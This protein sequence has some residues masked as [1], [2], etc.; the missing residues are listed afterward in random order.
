MPSLRNLLIVAGAAL[1]AGWGITT[2]LQVHH[3]HQ[4]TQAE[5]VSQQQDQ[6]AQAHAQAAQAIPHHAAALAAA[7]AR[8]DVAE[9][10]AKAAEAQSGR[11]LKER[12][13][14]LAR[15]AAQAPAPPDLRDQVIAKDK[16]VI[17][18]QVAQ[19]DGLHG[20]VVALEGQVGQL[21]LAFSDEQARSA[22]WQAAYQHEQSARLAQEAAT[23]AW[24]DAVRESRWRGRIE[25]F[26]AG[27]ALGYAGGKL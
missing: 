18:A 13:A 2:A 23:R 3:Q 15:L 7:Q 17:S 21:K 20:Q 19:I 6:Q 12:A 26:A 25:G 9:A 11:L 1:L 8:A 16:E 10:Q 22:Q 5:Q 4:G 14:L 24:K 27:V